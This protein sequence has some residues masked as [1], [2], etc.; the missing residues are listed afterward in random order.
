M[1][2]LTTRARCD[3]SSSSHTLSL[4]ASFLLSSVTCAG[5]NV[6][7]GTVSVSPSVSPVPGKGVDVGLAVAAPA[8]A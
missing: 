8:V 1:G 4:L 7:A 3:I 2:T 5:V 6:D